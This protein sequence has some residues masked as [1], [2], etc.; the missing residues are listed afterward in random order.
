MA[1]VKWFVTACVVAVVACSTSVVIDTQQSGDGDGGT[2]LVYVDAG[3]ASDDGSSAI[4][5]DV[6]LLPDG[7]P[8]DVDTQCKHNY[9]I[10]SKSDFG[11]GVCFSADINGCVP[12]TA[13]S[14]FVDSCDVTANY[15]F[16]CGDSYDTTTFTDCVI[17]G[18]GPIGEYYWCCTK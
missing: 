9:C 2:V 8:C 7:A 17:V 12:I 11:S 3:D 10:P 16:T 4:D 15:M 1:R 6:L 5:A 18:A 14:P 13:P